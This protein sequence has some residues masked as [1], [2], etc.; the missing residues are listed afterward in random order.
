[1]I[2]K[3]ENPGTGKYQ[4]KL[5]GRIDTGT[6]EE[7]WNSLSSIA[8]DAAEI[9]LDFAD[10]FY[11]GS[12]GLRTLLQLRKKYSN[13]KIVITH[14]NPEIRNIFNFTGFDVYFEVDN[15]ASDST[16]VYLS[17]KDFLSRKLREAPDKIILGSESGTYTWRDVD[18]ASGIIA[19]D[20]SE[21]G[22]KKGTHVGLCGMNSASWIFTFF[23]IQRLGGIAMLINPGLS[24][25]ELGVV[26]AIGD[27]TH[28]CCG[29]MPR[30]KDE[31]SFRQEL[32]HIDGCPVTQFYSFR[33]DNIGRER[34]DEY[35]STADFLSIQVESDDPCVVI[36]TSG[37]TGKPKGVLLSAFNILNAAGVNSAI[38]KLS[39]ED[40][41]CLILPLFHIFGLSAGFFVNAISNATVYIAADTRTE[42]IMKLLSEKEC[43]I[44]HAVPTTLVALMNNE[45]FDSSKFSSLRCTIIAG[46]AAKEAQLNMFKANLP[47]VHFISTYGLSEMAPV[48][49][50][51]Y[52]DTD[53]H[54]VHTVGKPV[55]HIELKIMNTESGEECAAGESGEVLVKGF[56]LMTGYYKQPV[57]DQSVDIDGWLHTG[58]LGFL[59]ENGYLHLSERL[60]ELIIRGGENIMP[61]EVE[62]AI[63]DLEIVEN[64]KVI[65][66][67]SDFFGEEVGACIK[68]KKGNVFDEAEMKQFLSTKLAK[69][70]IPKYYLIYD[71]F[72]L[73]GSGKIDAVSL[74]K[75]AI[76]RISEGN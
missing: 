20:L 30:A 65:G 43:T 38:V 24:A 35:S 57:E 50:T 21:L 51:L 58:D 18:I 48:T 6:C 26:A 70:K 36:F 61:A 39:E 25:Q 69:F 1:M 52:D 60:K 45:L 16:Y 2:L 32:V 49:S 19:K 75:D 12:M 14:T 34:K 59:D 22:V 63:S 13:A 68:L 72:P 17:F 67:P 40:R 62:S 33:N 71:Q 55:H 23:A 31:D 47:N 54:L 11:I 64:V 8:E 3:T 76:R 10:V 56:N 28:L 41:V 73:L 15:T 29:N 53:D 46:A 42:T 4:V 9:I 5:T 44:F 7:I 37:S 74:K 27:I 66:V